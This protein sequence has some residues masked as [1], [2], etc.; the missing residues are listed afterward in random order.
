MKFDRFKIGDLADNVTDGEH[1]S[2][3]DDANGKYYLLSNKNIKNSKIS[4]DESDRKIA[5]VSF[6][7]I[8]KRTK[9]E[10]NDVVISTVG[11]IGRTAIIKDEDIKYDFQRSVGIIKTDKSKLLPEYL[12]Y[13]FQLPYV[14]KRL[15]YLSSGAVQKCL[16]ISDLR[17]IEI[18]I[19][20]RFEYQKQI[21]KVL[22]DLDAK[23]EVN[24]KI[25]KELEALAKTIYD[26]WFVQFDFPDENGKPYKSS[27]GKMVYNEELKREIPEG[28]EQSTIADWIENHANG[29]WGK[30]E[31]EGKY[32]VE[33]NCIRGADLPS[34]DGFKSNQSPTR[35]IH[36]NKTHKI[37]KSDDLIVEISG[38]S[39]T[40]STGRI[41]F[42]T[43]ETFKRYEAP[44]ICAN[45]CKTVRLKNPKNLYNFYY[46]WKEA[47]DQGNMFN[48]EG[49]TSGI[50]NLLFSSLVE[51]FKVPVPDRKLV[52][53]FYEFMKPIQKQKQQNLLENQKLA[54]LRDWL[55]PMLMNGQVRVAQSLEEGNIGATKENNTI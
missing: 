21:A 22:S 50:R 14:Q 51:S 46:T 35:Y 47:F 27:G 7:K 12:H 48:Y 38:G 53:E 33:V 2:V 17:N 16:F 37:L 32:T 18:D 36:E 5:K 55:L 13:Y 29:D 4:Y 24:N 54:E 41:S 3:I 28:W 26:Y 8:N 6:E 44:L 52:D 43:E 19:P 34:L 42:V 23:I 30:S 45:F 25:N 31:P 11:S 10:K 39:P 49:K 20:D 9:L 40:Q 1:G 15:N